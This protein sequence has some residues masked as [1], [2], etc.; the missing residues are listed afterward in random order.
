MKVYFF[1]VGAAHLGGE[2]GVIQF[3]TEKQAIL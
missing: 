3:I 2:I 1:A